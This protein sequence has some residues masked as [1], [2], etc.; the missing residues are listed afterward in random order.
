MKG[1]QKMLI[2]ENMVI[3]G[4]R[5]IVKSYAKINLTLDVLGR[6]ENGYHEIE[7][8]MQ[9][10][11]LFDLIVADKIP[12]GIKLH[13]NLKFLP[14]NEKNIAYKAAALF[15]A[16]TGICGGVKI[17][18]HKNIPV[19]AGLAG[20]SGNGAAVLAALNVLYN[21]HLTDGELFAMA[22]ELGADV[23]YCLVGGTVLAEGIGEK[24][25]PLPKMGR[26]IVLLAKPPINVSTKSI[27][28]YIDSVEISA[29]PK[30]DVMIEGIKSDNLHRIADN[31]LNVMEEA[32]VKLHPVIR[33]IKEKMM[34][35]GAVGAI[36]SGSGPTVFGLFDDYEKAKRSHDSFSKMYKD[37]YLTYT[38]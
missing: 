14:T 18:I 32:T 31:I 22:K 4:D 19:A 13:T 15:F 37:V 34:L 25:T 1:I 16:K 28:D 9:T 35:N 23:P 29:R 36:M 27:Y 5:A 21:A 11:G 26:H 12:K 10:V 7:S 20:G 17:L 30:L 6:M 38:L 24:L 3:N 8:I 2:R 33:G